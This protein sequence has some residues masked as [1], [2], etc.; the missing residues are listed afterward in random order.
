MAT[1][2]SGGG[3]MSPSGPA[4]YGALPA[5][6]AA[7]TGSFT[8]TDNPAVAG[9]GDTIAATFQLQDGAANLGT[10]AFTL[11]VG[12]VMTGFAQNF[13]GVTAPSLPASWI[14]SA[15]G[16]QSTWIT[17]TTARD[18]LPNA[19]FSSEATSVGVNELVSP[20]VIIPAR[21]TQLSFRNKFD[22][23]ADITGYDGGVLEIKIG[24]GAFVDILAAGGSFVSGGYPETLSSFGNPSGRQAWSGQSSGFVNTV[25]P[26]PRRAKPPSSAGVAVRTVASAAVDGMWTRSR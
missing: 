16:A 14:T 25:N 8:F 22:L 5:G 20:S 3:V 17:S 1:L 11:R 12:Q 10:V 15:S 21:T 13:D 9:C 7:V 18:T 2:L 23:E 6:G 24:N 4:D 19:A 26:P